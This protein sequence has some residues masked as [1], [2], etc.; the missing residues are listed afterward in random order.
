M[1]DWSPFQEMRQMRDQVD[2]MFGHSLERFQGEPG[3][4]DSWLER[5]YIPAVDFKSEEDSY[6]VRM[7]IPGIDKSEI[8]VSI[9]G[10]VLQIKGQREKLIEKKEGE[11]LISTERLYGRFLRSFTMPGGI[12]PDKS[13]AKYED[14]VLT[15]TIPKGEET[16]VTHKIEVE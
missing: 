8:E 11:K 3:F 15:V 2:R 10:L 4:D 16:D 14:G 12:D 7:D 9:E 5:P 6:L 13:T 1:E